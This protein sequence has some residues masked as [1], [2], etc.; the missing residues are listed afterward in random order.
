VSARS[1]RHHVQTYVSQE[2][3]EQ[4]LREAA[5]QRQSVSECIRTALEEIYAIREELGRPLERDTD[6]ESPGTR[7]GHRV[8]GQFEERI[9]GGFNRQIDEIERLRDQLRRL[10]AMVDRQYVGLMLHLP[11][12]DADEEQKRS[13]SASRRYHAWRRAVDKLLG[14]SIR[15]P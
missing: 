8:L 12:A 10:E 3:Y 13:A 4:I 2:L 9:V 6:E 7:L 11:D 15:R 14:S 5:V 1:A